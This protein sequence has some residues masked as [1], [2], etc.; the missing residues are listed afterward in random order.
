MPNTTIIKRIILI[1]FTLLAVGWAL[2]TTANPAIDWLIA[3]AQS[4]GAYTTDNDIATPFTATAETIQTLYKLGETSQPTLPPALSFISSQSFPST[5]RLSQ[6]LILYAGAGQPLSP[7]TSQLIAR[8]NL[9]G[10]IGDLSDYDSTVIDT[11]WALNALAV[12]DIPV[13]TLYPAINYLLEQQHQN[14]GWADY[15]NDTSI[16][17]TALVMQALWQYRHHIPTL[18]EVLDQAQS[19][20]LAQ[21]DTNGAWNETFETALALIAILPRLP[22]PDSLSDSL[23]ALQTA[24]LTNGSWDNDV[25]TTALALRAFQT[26]HNLIPR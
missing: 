19:Y 14:G 13:E 26:T 21:R 4:N 7:I 2:P 10:G 17:T 18:N 24:Q 25:Y 15:D 9:N 16:Y 5:K 12:T 1:F 20:L 8:L 6:T 11:A 22:N 23:D 3:T